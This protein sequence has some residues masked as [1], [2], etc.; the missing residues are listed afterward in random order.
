M[1]HARSASRDDPPR[2]A[3]VASRK[4]GGAVA[5]NRAKRLIREA[6]RQLK[7]KRGTDVVVIARKE[8]AGSNARDVARELAA[9]GQALDVIE[10]S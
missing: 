2:M 5:R 6:G 8:C 7:W 9:L 4:V 1:L 10:S 3:V